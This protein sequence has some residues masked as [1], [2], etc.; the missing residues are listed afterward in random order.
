M[1]IKGFVFFAFSAFLSLSD[2][3][4]YE[5]CGLSAVL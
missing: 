5:K 2:V 4:F 1:E 3:K